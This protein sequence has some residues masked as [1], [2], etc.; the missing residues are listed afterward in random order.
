MQALL[1]RPPKIDRKQLF[2][3]L[4]SWIRQF[5]KVRLTGPR[6]WK[7]PKLRRLI[8]IRNLHA[9]ERLT[10][11]S[12]RP[13]YLQTLDGLQTRQLISHHTFG[14]SLRSKQPFKLYT[15]S[16]LT[17]NRGLVLNALIA[18][19]NFDKKWARIWPALRF[20]NDGTFYIFPMPRIKT[21]IIMN[22][23][24]T[25]QILQIHSEEGAA[26]T[27]PT[28]QQNFYYHGIRIPRSMGKVNPKLWTADMLLKTN[29]AE[30]QALLIEQLGFERI[31]KDLKMIVTDTWN[32]YEL[33]KR[34]EDV[35]KPIRD[36]LRITLLK[37][38]CPSTGKIYVNR[39]PPAVLTAKEAI[40]WMNHDIEP[41]A[42]KQQ[43]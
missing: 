10:R 19:K 5:R 4:Q 27:L 21:R 17:R 1:E 39:V 30:I 18:I 26:L 24:N 41:E 42:F 28:G 14:P 37:M 6:Y 2:K 34:E 40:T 23:E 3:D 29:N 38:T 36:P 31:L 43:S 22:R 33:F 7:F 15:R 12:G 8:V 16:Y 9:F 20:E 11:Y 25:R 13:L 32:G 35:V